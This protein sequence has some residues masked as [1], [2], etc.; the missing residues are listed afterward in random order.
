MPNKFRKLPPL[1]T[2]IVFE[3]AFRLQ[4]F[5]RAA[6]EV[7]LSPA[8]VSR[9]IRELEQDLGVQL[10]DRRRYDVLP[11]IDGEMFAAT[12]RLSLNELLAAA[13]HVRNR[14]VA[15]NRLTIFSDI[16]LAN[17]LITPVLGEFHRH[18]PDI[19]LHVLSSS[20]PIEYINEEFDVGLQYGRRAETQ[21]VIEHISDEIIFPCA[22]HKWPNN[23]QPVVVRTKLQNNRYCIFVTRNARGLPGRIS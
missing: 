2:L 12:V 8:S 21:F 17:A 18:Y 10:F 19:K 5:T 6:D 9:R 1:N 14:S 20:E 16:S 3:A 7:A 11:T 4:S 23:C 13:D 15:S 22:L